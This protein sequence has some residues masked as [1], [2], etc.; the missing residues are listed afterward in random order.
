MSPRPSSAPQRPTSPSQHAVEV[1]L[2]SRVKL[3]RAGHSYVAQSLNNNALTIDMSRLNN[4]TVD[5]SS[6][7]ATIGGGSKLGDVALSLWEQ[8]QRQ[9]G[10]GTCPFVGAGGHMVSGGFGLAGRQLGLSID[11]VVGHE[12]VLANGSVVQTSNTSNTDLFWALRGGGGSF[13]AFRVIAL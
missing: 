4:V 7:I 10:H 2:A 11:R 13:G 9:L 8:G 12:V 3:K 1:S 6:G 5:Q